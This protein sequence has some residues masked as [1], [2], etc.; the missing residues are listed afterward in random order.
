MNTSNA[1]GYAYFFKLTGIFVS[2][3]AALAGVLN[4]L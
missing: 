1:F 2:S 3:G 4:A